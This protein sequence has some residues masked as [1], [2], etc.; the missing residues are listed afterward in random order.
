MRP[1][2][3]AD[4]AG[5][6]ETMLS[7]HATL[8]AVVAAVF[9][10]NA[11]FAAE[12]P[13][14]S[15]AQ[16][17]APVT[18]VLDRPA[19]ASALAAKSLLIGMARAGDKFVAVGPRG[20]IVVTADGGQ[21]WTQAKVPVSS[22]L[23]AVWF[24]SPLL[25][26]AVGHDGVVLASS[27]GGATWTKQ[28]DGRIA[29]DLALKDIQAKLAADPGSEELKALEAEAQRNVE[30]GADKPFLDVWFENETTGF[31]V[32]AY[33]LIFATTDGGQTWQSW[34][35]RVPNPQFMSLYSIRPAAGN[36]FIAGEQGTFFRLDREAMKFVAVPVDYVGSLFGVVDAGDAVLTFGI[37]GRVFRSADAGAT[38]TPVV[39]MLPTTIVAGATLAPGTVVL[40]DQSGRV[41]MS[42]DGGSTFEPVQ[43]AR[44]IPLTDIINAG[45]GRLGVTGPFGAMIVTPGAPPAP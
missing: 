16:A 7:R 44:T 38:W 1:G 6:G 8:A 32:G 12:E 28:M 24:A 33:N 42:K 25:G 10:S 11:A 40:A 29:N 30:M 2:Q 37:K 43:L 17:P 3:G 15:G 27:D 41:S 35:D 13:T 20:H 9:I 31:V 5:T 36:V 39:S 45:D 18:D 23:T 22:D 19:M 4:K 26:W 21:T 34:F 14:G